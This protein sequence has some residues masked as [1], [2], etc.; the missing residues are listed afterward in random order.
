MTCPNCGNIMYRLNNRMIYCNEC[1]DFMGIYGAQGDD[2]PYGMQLLEQP[3][4]EYN[5]LHF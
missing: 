3:Q 2:I 1:D 4:T 5:A